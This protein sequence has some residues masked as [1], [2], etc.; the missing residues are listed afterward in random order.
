MMRAIKATNSNKLRDGES[1][2]ERERE[3]ES[4]EGDRSNRA[5]RM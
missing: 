4:D 5:P 1:D 3:R 2:L